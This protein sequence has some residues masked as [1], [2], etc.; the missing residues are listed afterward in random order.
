MRAH[1][2][3]LLR[4]ALIALVVSSGGACARGPDDGGDAVGSLELGTGS[5][6]FEPIVDGDHLELIR[7]SQGGWHVWTSLRTT[8]IAT[9]SSLL[10]LDTE[11]ADESRP[12]T[13]T[14]VMVHLDPPN[15]EGQ[16]AIIG[17]PNQILE[18]S[19]L[20]GEMLHVRARMTDDD[21]EELVSER[22]FVPMGGT[23]PPPPCDTD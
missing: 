17:W 19:C 11:P 22:W 4:L 8:N 6:R 21:G 13:H 12:P 5:W 7:G 23:Y 10:V 16:R 1:L 14:E 3:S 9:D 2:R 20:V 15:H 18:P